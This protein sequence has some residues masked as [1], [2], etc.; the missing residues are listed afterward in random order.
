MK[1]LLKVDQ[2]NEI[3]I[4][5]GVPETTEPEEAVDSSR[6]ATSKFEVQIKGVARLENMSPLELYIQND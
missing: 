6:K 3:A 2:S 5:S 1:N 4:D